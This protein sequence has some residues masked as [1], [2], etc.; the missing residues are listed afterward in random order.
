MRGN[1]HVHQAAARF[2]KTCEFIFFQSRTIRRE[3]GIPPETV[4]RQGCRRPSA[5]WT[6]LQRVPEASTHP[7]APPLLIRWEAPLKHQ[8]KT[9]LNNETINHNYPIFILN[10]M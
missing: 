6:G 1:D 4:S 9:G 2:K 7:G 5:P 8:I 10:S 3:L